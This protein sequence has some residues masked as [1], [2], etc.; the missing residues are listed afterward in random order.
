MSGKWVG[1]PAQ[2]FACLLAFR[3]AITAT[4][5]DAELRSLEAYSA[6]V[7]REK[8]TTIICGVM[9]DRAPGSRHA[10]FR[11]RPSG[12]RVALTS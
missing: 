7:A 3:R 6:A 4:R 10:A 9:T 2:L 5:I 8:G 1:H 12:A 11:S